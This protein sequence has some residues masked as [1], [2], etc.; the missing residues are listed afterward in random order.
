MAN[1]TGFSRPTLSDLNDR[2][3]AD[4][5]SG[6]T[7]ADS[8]LRRSFLG[9]IGRAL[10]GLAHGLYGYL[11]WIAKQAIP[12]TASKSGLEAWCRVWGVTRKLA[13]KASGT[14]TFT[15]TNGTVVASGTQVI[16]SDGALYQTTAEAT[17]ASGSVSLSL[18]AV[19]AGAAGNS[20][21][22]VT[23]KFVSPVSGVNASGSVDAAGIGGGADDEKDDAL[24]ARLLERI[25][26]PPQGGADLDYLRWAKEVAGVTRAWVVGGEMGA[27][28]VTVRFMMDGTYADGIP[29][30]AD[31]SD[32]EDYINDSSRRP[33]TASLYV[34]API[35]DTLDITIADLTP[36][37][38]AVKAA[39]EAELKDMILR[40]AEPGGTIPI[41]KIWEAV[42]IAT[43]ETSH[44]ITSPTADVTHTTGK[45]A[46]L[47]TITYA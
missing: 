26:Q 10:A 11:G 2:V 42:S 18:E 25:Q 37:T 17:V 12:D 1:T 40:V 28:T 24:L 3:K 20:V 7:G 46:T 36:N 30:A 41:S 44:Q 15:G 29:Q 6:L 31:V 34:A 23:L 22:G 45:I 38:T 32:V 13:S 43:G 9:T 4:I 19:K 33:V 5:N 35:A 8:R 21:S 47:G 16:R 39:I 14:A 27:G